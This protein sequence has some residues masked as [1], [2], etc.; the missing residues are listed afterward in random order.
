MTKRPKLT[1]TAAAQ[2]LLD[3]SVQIEIQL[4]A[5]TGGAPL[6]TH[7]NRSR[8]RSMAALYALAGVN[9]TDTETIR[10]HQMHVRM[11]ELLLDDL[12]LIV[13]KGREAEDYLDQET[14]SEIAAAV[15]LDQ[16]EDGTT[17][18]IED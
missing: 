14:A 8:K 5:K 12:K 16:F 7:L 3:L 2:R 4:T 9:P 18:D 10:Q 17:P 1:P 13:A 6:A 11:H 15:G